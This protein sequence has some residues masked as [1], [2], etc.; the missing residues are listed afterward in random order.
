MPAPLRAAQNRTGSPYWRFRED[1]A[2]NQRQNR[3]MWE[4]CRSIR[5]CREGRWPEGSPEI[6]TSP[7]NAVRRAFGVAWPMDVNVIKETAPAEA[8]GAK[9]WIAADFGERLQLLDVHG[10][11][12]VVG[13]RIRRRTPVEQ[14]PRA[15]IVSR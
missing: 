14:S 4:C 8:H 5:H 10:R 12:T 1:T 6:L 11:I 7:I 13:P 3:R 15:G 2:R 9:E